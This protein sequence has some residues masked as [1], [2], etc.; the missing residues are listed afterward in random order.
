MG[1][2]KKWKNWVARM[3]DRTCKE[4]KEMH[5]KIYAIDEEVEPA[6]PLHMNGRCTI[7]L[8][9]TILAGNATK[10]G[11]EGADWYLKYYGTLPDYYVNKKDA[12]KAGWRKKKGNLADKLPGKMLFGEY[13]NRNNKLPHLINR[14][15]YEADINYARGHRNNERI[16]FSNDGLIFVTYDHYDTFSEIK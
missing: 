9:K 14:H 7:E 3:D 16:L 15:W 13:E 6:P 5:G 11:A 10:K 2:S 8:L 1:K 12:R 4:C